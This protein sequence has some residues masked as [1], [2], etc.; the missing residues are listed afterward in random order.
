RVTDKHT[1]Y[2]GV[3][4]LTRHVAMLNGIP[5]AT[6]FRSRLPNV[7]ELQSIL[8]YQNVLPAVSPAF[9]NNCSA[10]CSATTCSCTLEGD[11]WS[12]TSSVSGPSNAWFV[13]FQYANV[14]SFG[15][16]GGK[17]GTASSRA[18]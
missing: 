4:A 12:S 1:L 2:A 17:S 5:Y 3:N 7:R 15:R 14:N 18:V 9:N 8:N 13:G 6:L 16:T 10:G 11:Y